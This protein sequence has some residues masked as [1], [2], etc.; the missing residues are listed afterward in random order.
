MALQGIYSV[1]SYEVKNL[2]EEEEETNNVTVSRPYNA[3][4]AGG[5][6]NADANC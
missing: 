5:R 4:A 1:W 3:V 2:E 6:I